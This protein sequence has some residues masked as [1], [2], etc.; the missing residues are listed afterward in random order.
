[1]HFASPGRIERRQFVIQSLLATGS[2]CVPNS[3]IHA[4]EKEAN[5]IDPVCPPR[6]DILDKLQKLPENHG[7]LLGKAAVVGDFNETA[8]K[9][10]LDRTGPRARDYCLKMVWAPERK[11]VLFC[12][13]N[14][15]VPHRLN[16]VWEFDLPSLTWVMLYA[17]DLTRGYLDLGK[18]RSDVRV[19]D[20]VL[21]TMRGGPAIVGHTWWGLTYDPKAK[22]MLFLNTWVTDAAKMVREM[23]GDPTKLDSGPPLW[24]FDPQGKRW[25]PLHAPQPQSKP[26]FVSVFGGMLEYLPEWNG[27]VWHVNNWQTRGMWRHDFQADR[28]ELLTAK[29]DAKAFEANAPEPEQI[30]YYDP[31]RKAIFV[32]RHRDTFRCDVPTLTWTRLRKGNADDGQS[33]DGHDARSVLAHDPHSGHGLLCHFES[34]ALWALDPDAVKWTR[35]QPQGDPMPRGH[36][37]LAY[38]DPA[39][40]VWVVMHDTTIWAYRYRNISS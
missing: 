30:G 6:A 38:F 31:K 5:P 17:P 39:A 9:F 7:I 2:F 33:P 35:L 18:D 3:M 4:K 1:M 32:Q 13:A 26:P 19:A 37:R 34:N 40:N 24:A 20:G 27:A 28:W 23:G 15:G 22:R 10:E 25:Q 12:G 29:H 8:R 11:R 16:D 21:Q 36:K 14:H